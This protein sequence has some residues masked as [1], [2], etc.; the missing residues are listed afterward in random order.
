MGGTGSGFREIKAAIVD[1]CLV[2][3]I[4]EL[5]RDRVL[6]PGVSQRRNWS[7]PGR[8]ATIQ[9]DSDLRD[10]VP[11]DGPASIHRR[12]LANRHLDFPRCH[13]V[14]LRWSTAVVQMLDDRPASTKRIR[15]S[16]AR[17]FFTTI[18]PA[19]HGVA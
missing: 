11:C 10:D 17:S 13:Q 6:V 7:W 16:T 15:A 8:N 5:L 2:L 4:A 1:D 18:R 14:A 12:R 19:P 3:S 9:I